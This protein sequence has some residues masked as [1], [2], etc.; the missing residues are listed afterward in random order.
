[1]PEAGHLRSVCRC[2]LLTSSARALTDSRQ[3]AALIGRRAQV[4]LDKAGFDAVV[5]EFGN[6]LPGA[7]A[8][9]TLAKG[10]VREV[11]VTTDFVASAT[12]PLLISQIL[13]SA[14]CRVAFAEKQSWSS[15]SLTSFGFT[16][17]CDNA[18]FAAFW[19]IPKPRR[20]M[21]DRSNSDG[22]SVANCWP[23]IWMA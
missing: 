17:A 15:T 21:D 6:Q 14:G 10:Q 20:L 22:E 8:S 5:Q 23:A 1:M 2:W 18:S 3:P 9:F 16:F 7:D 11:A 12:A 4:D 13:V 19:V